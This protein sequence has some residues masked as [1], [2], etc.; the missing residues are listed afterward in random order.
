MLQE[1]ESVVLFSPRSNSNLLNLQKYSSNFFG[2]NVKKLGTNNK[3]E[4]EEKFDELFASCLGALRIIKD[5]W[6]TEA[7]P[8]LT[9]KNGEKIGFL[10]KIFR[11]TA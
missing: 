2:L 6:E 4:G 1:R 9:N 11:N 8:E 3:K 7:I 5:G 10:G